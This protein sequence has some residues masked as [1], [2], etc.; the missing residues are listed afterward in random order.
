MFANSF[1]P[2]SSSRRL[3]TLAL[4]GFLSLSSFAADTAT[5]QYRWSVQYLL[6]QSQS[7]FGRSQSTSPRNNRGLAMSP[8]KHYLYAAY[9]WT[10]SRRGDFGPKGELRKIDLTA[11]D[12]EEATV[13]LLPSKIAKA[14]AVDEVGRV[15]AA[16][17]SQISV[18]DA[19][20]AHELFVIPTNECDGV[21]VAKSGSK[22]ILY[23]SE[24]KN[25]SLKRFELTGESEGS[26]SKAKQTGFDGGTGEISIPGSISLRGVAVDA[27]GRIWLADAG[28]DKVFRVNENGT[29]LKSIK[30][31]APMG[32]AFDGPK[33]YVTLSVDRAVA[34]I[35]DEMNVAG[36]VA[37]PWKELELSELGNNHEGIF[38]GIVADPGKGFY[39]ANAHGQTASQHSTYGR[40]DKFSE[41]LKGKL[42]TDTTADD[43]DPILHAVLTTGEPPQASG[44]TQKNA[45]DSP[46]SVGSVKPGAPPLLPSGMPPTAGDQ[47]SPRG[48]K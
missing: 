47:A 19:D 34:V 38:A 45:P 14:L 10:V 35:D 27:R 48:A 30:L 18:F 9:I 44:Q 16:M 42:F 22:V 2:V 20:L 1:I 17:G 12:Y 25:H 39:V 26:I 13:A 40:I 24:R 23:A 11:A 5:E 6:D 8:D 7:V 29:N 4:S 36:S 32:I 3:A 21:A 41:V 33:G 31:K 15:Y 46:M 37:M 43:N 28:A